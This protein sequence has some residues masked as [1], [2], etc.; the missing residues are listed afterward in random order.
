[1]LLKFVNQNSVCSLALIQYAD[2]FVGWHTKLEM[3]TLVTV[4]A[5]G[6]AGWL[7]A[8]AVIIAVFIAIVACKPDRIN[9]ARAIMTNI[10]IGFIR[11]NA[12]KKRK[13]SN[14]YEQQAVKVLGVMQWN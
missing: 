14:E 7:A 12:G 6:A 13:T 3:L 5:A 1:M 8:T 2:I 4:I 9:F 11:G 10:I